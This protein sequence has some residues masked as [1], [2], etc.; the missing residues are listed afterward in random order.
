MI[1]YKV[2]ASIGFQ[3]GGS[4]INVLDGKV[5]AKHITCYRTYSDLGL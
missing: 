2:M 4:I 5:N 3:N 1:V